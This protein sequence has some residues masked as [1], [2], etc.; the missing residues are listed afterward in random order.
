MID[1]TLIRRGSTSVRRLSLAPGEATPWHRDPYHRVT[2]ILSGDK[3]AIEDRDTGKID[4]LS[5]KSGQVDWDEPS[6]RVHRG[7][8]TGAQPYEEITVFFLDDPSSIPQPA[9]DLD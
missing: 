3:L 2:V 8:N 1:E 6:I 5:I 4:R 7:I 9:D